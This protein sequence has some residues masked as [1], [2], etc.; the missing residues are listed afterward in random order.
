MYIYFL[1]NYVHVLFG[2]RED[3]VAVMVSSYMY[4]GST[5]MYIIMCH[6]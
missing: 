3:S 5:Y 4:C 6:K 2:A 1:E